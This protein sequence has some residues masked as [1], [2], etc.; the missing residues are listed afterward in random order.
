MKTDLTDPDELLDGALR[1][2]D[3]ATEIAQARFDRLVDQTRG[4]AAPR[5]RQRRIQ[6]AVIIAGSCLALGGL[7]IAGTTLQDYLLSKPP[8]VGLDPGEQRSDEHIKYIPPV[9]ADAGEHCDL[10]PEFIG[11]TNAQLDAV[12][13]AITTQDWSGL[14]PDAAKLIPTEPDPS[15][16]EGEAVKELLVQRLQTAVPG[17]HQMDVQSTAT[18]SGAVLVGYTYVCR[19]TW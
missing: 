10:Y 19:G 7:L 18:P 4:Q 16:A 14:G 2:A 9:G 3:P 15:V 6:K 8:Y 11:L 5:R 12:D 13:D 1:R 17:L